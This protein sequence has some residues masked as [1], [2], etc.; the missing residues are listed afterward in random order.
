MILKNY[1]CCTDAFIILLLMTIKYK[2]NFLYYLDLIF[3]HLNHYLIF[4]CDVR[5]MV[6]DRTFYGRYLA[7]KKMRHKLTLSC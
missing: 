2:K 6:M 4:T 7:S 5:C 3:E 1:T